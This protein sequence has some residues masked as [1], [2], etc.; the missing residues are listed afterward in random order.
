MSKGGP[1][2]AARS[3]PLLFVASKGVQQI[4][5]FT[6]FS[7]GPQLGLDHAQARRRLVEESIPFG[8][9]AFD[10][11]VAM[12]PINRITAGDVFFE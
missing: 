12:D 1:R 10:W 2:A 4:G 7:A 6:D 8:A 3:D 9:G 5:P 11:T